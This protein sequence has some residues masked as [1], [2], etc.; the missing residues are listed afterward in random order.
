MF[1]AISRHGRWIGRC[2]GRWLSHRLG[3]DHPDF[4]FELAHYE[5]VELALSVAEDENKT[6]VDSGG[7][8]LDGIVC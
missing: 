2:D 6:P 4:L 5:W 3:M 8:L 7:D 1:L